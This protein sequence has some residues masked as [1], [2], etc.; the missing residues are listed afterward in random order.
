MPHT[1]D[2]PSYSSTTPLS[3]VDDGKLP[4]SAVTVSSG[5]RPPLSYGPLIPHYSY[6]SFDEALARTSRQALGV[7]AEESSPLHALFS[8]TN[9]TLYDFALEGQD[10]THLTPLYEKYCKSGCRNYVAVV[11][12]AR[13]RIGGFLLD[14]HVAFSLSR[15]MGLS[16]LHVPL[17]PA[18]PERYL[19]ERLFGLGRGE[20]YRY[21]EICLAGFNGRVCRAFLPCLEVHL[22]QAEGDGRLSVGSLRDTVK[23]KCNLVMHLPGRVD[24]DEER[25]WDE[26]RR[27]YADARKKVRARAGDCA[28]TLRYSTRSR[29]LS[30]KNTSTLRYTLTPPTARRRTGRHRRARPTPTQSWPRRSR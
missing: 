12:N 28:L 14:W 22:V 27:R 5:G 13:Q 9:E 17:T 2:T 19:F 11:P 29:S 26:M 23:D 16:F 10:P 6:L 15:E 24:H 21:R 1:A 18:Q 4:L 25:G 8:V 20:P 30:I 3:E 7:G